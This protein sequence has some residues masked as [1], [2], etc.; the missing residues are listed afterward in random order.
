MSFDSEDEKAALVVDNGSGVIK[1]GFAGNDAPSVLFSTIV[2]HPRRQSIM[3]GTMNKAN[4]IGDEAQ[5]NRGVLSLRYPMEHGIITNW[6]DMEKIWHHTFY[7]ELRVA[8]EEH[9]ILLTDPCLNPKANRE[10]MTQVMLETFNFPAFHVSNEVYL[11][12][13]ALGRTAGIIC[14]TGDGTTTVLP[15][16]EGY[17]IRHAMCRADIGGR[18]LTN[19]L[20]KLLNTKGNRFVTTADNE[21][22]R[23][24]KEKC[25]RVSLQYETEM[26]QT[27]TTKQSFSLP[28]G[29]DITLDKEQFMCPEALFKPSLIGMD[30]VPGIH[31]LI[32]SSLMKCDIDVRRDM[33]CNIIVSGG[34]SMFPNFA[35][36]LKQEISALIPERMRSRLTRII[37]PPERKY[38]AWIGGSIIA[39]LST[40]QQKWITKEEYNEFGPSIVHRRCF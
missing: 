38:S 23:E 11:A 19:Y 26:M 7:S 33:Y 17:A 30:S 28:D 29:R 37:A 40:F 31:E 13:Y 18:D 20:R 25:T 15:I 39:S 34:N 35:E 1:A 8:P 21:I 16:Y 14:Q 36:R 4:Y 9:P 2:G 5:M 12:F 6:D 32:Y 3:L 22:V 27:S 24:I 10:K